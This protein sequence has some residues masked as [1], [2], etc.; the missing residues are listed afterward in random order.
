V[1][2]LRDV[3]YVFDNSD[4]GDLLTKHPELIPKGMDAADAK[5]MVEPEAFPEIAERL[6]RT[7]LTD[8]QI[9]G[10]LGENWLRVA[11]QVWRQ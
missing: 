7:S 5:A 4:W 10:I 8:A 3:K 11:T 1:I 6:A 2:Q 9:R